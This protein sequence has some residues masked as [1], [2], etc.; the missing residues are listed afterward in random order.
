MT[1]PKSQPLEANNGKCPEC[2]KPIAHKYRPFCSARCAN[3]DLG[4][5]FNEEYQLPGDTEMPDD[6]T[7]L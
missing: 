3:L 7:E 5:W 6:I 2:A 4:K 1:Q